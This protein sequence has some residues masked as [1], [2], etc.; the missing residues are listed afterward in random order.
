MIPNEPHPDLGLDLASDTAQD[1]DTGRISLS[2]TTNTT[3]NTTHSARPGMQVDDHD[4]WHPLDLQDDPSFEGLLHHPMSTSTPQKGSAVAYSNTSFQ[5]ESSDDNEEDEL[6]PRGMR[7]TRQRLANLPLV[8]EEAQHKLSSTTTISN[9]RGSLGRGPLSSPMYAPSPSTGSSTLVDPREDELDHMMARR[10]LKGKAKPTRDDEETT[11]RHGTNGRN[12]GG[13]TTLREEVEEDEDEE[14]E[15]R[16]EIPT[17]RTRPYDDERSTSP[18]QP[19]THPTPRRRGVKLESYVQ[20][21]TTPRYN[22]SRGGST[23][24]P[25]ATAQAPASSPP[26]SSREPITATTQGTST[27][28]PRSR[29]TGRAQI[30]D[31]FNRFIEGPNGALTLSAE[32]R[33]ALTRKNVQAEAETQ[34]ALNKSKPSSLKASSSSSTGR[35]NLTNLA[36]PHPT[37]YYA[38]ASGSTKTTTTNNSRVKREEEEGGFAASPSVGGTRGFRN[39][40]TRGKGYEGEKEEPIRKPFANNRFARQAF[41]EEGDRSRERNPRTQEY[42]GDNSAQEEEEDVEE[43]EEQGEEAV[44]RATGGGRSAIEYA[45]AK[46]FIAS[47]VK[48]KLRPKIIPPSPTRTPLSKRSSTTPP[49]STKNLKKLSFISPSKSPVHSPPPRMT[50][51]TTGVTTYQ[52]P[53]HLFPSEEEEAEMSRE[54]READQYL[55]ELVEELARIVRSRSVESSREE[56]EEEESEELG[57]GRRGLNDEK[58]ALLRRNED[59]LR[60]AEECLREGRELEEE[61]REEEREG[62]MNEAT[63]QDLL[64]RL[65]EAEAIDDTLLS[66]M[67]ALRLSLDTL[68]RDLGAQVSLAVQTKLEQEASKRGNWLLWGVA[69]HLANYRAS[70]LYDSSFIDPFAHPALYYIS[71]STTSHSISEETL[72]VFSPVPRRGRESDHDGFKYLSL[73]MRDL[74]GRVAVWDKGFAVGGM[75]SSR[76]MV[77]RVPF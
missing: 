74:V 65:H 28:A 14:E 45:M 56:E 42:E 35:S 38:F 5:E 77:E 22:T 70:R 11:L 4:R 3:T 53:E 58:E 25:T 51:M 47:P 33:A 19:F 13:V 48:S 29:H 54:A 72:A 64:R 60:E 36:T 16:T 37:G 18:P 20:S 49:S 8:V 32:R 17:P 10:R 9:A 6:G 63:T 66:R 62:K 39:R 21:H 67:D 34:A 50:K 41:E 31:A 44:Y 57:Y 76:G 27:P 71:P 46:S 43:E 7:L 12:G 68:G 2:S 23:A 69:C 1:D 26:M 24:L 30:L 40:M 52:N 75:G 15:A 73:V 59:V 61:L 55:L